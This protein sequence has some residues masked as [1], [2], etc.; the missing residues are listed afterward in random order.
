MQISQ[1][2]VFTAALAVTFTAGARLTA[3]SIGAHVQGAQEVAEQVAEQDA[4]EV[5]EQKEW[6]MRQTTPETH[7]DDYKE[8]HADVVCSRNAKEICPQCKLA[9]KTATQI[10]E[11]YST[12]I[13]IYIYIY[14][15]A[16]RL[17]RIKENGTE[18]RH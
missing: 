12:S 15:A 6:E 7:P 14:M 8:I 16:S 11:T 18:G 1:L 9:R 2:F 3:G 10:Y 4:Q 5:A 17:L 13:H